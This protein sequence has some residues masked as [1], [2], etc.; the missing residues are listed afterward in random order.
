MN[1]EAR[2]AR[3]QQAPPA[4]ALVEATVALDGEDGC[5]ARA[6][7]LTGDFLTGVRRRD[8][9][10]VPARIVDLARLVVSELVTNALRHAPGPVLLRLRVA[11]PAVEIVVWDSDPALPRPCDPDPARVGRHGLEIVKAVADEFDAMREAVGKRVVARL[12]L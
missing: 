7:G 12:R 6:R 10:S 3:R 9:R 5:I 1:G 4:G 2:T 11:G 8:G